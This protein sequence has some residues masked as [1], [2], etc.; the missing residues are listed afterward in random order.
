MLQ[1]VKE[2]RPVK[3]VKRGKIAKA[4]KAAAV[5]AAKQAARE[6]PRA[7]KWMPLEAMQVSV[8]AVHLP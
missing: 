7:F 1:A 4:E 2:A 6:K 5:K 3:S 8:K